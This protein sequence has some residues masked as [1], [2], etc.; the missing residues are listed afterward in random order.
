VNDIDALLDMSPPALATFYCVSSVTAAVVPFRHRWFP[1]D[2]P[3]DW[4]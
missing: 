4:G 2:I 1:T 3:K